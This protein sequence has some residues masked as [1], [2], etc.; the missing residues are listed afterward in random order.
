MVIVTKLDFSLQL[1]EAIVV[2]LKKIWHV[3]NHLL[4]ASAGPAKRALANNVK[5]LVNLF[6]F[7]FNCWAKCGCM[8]QV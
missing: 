1:K 5:K 8:K 7:S 4:L 2:C 6:V 3:L